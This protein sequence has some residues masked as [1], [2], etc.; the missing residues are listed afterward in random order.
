MKDITISGSRNNGS[1]A[2]AGKST[3]AP[4]AP[5]FT[6]ESETEMTTL[7]TF[8]GQ[9][10]TVTTEFQGTKKFCL[11]QKG[12]PDTQKQFHQYHKSVYTRW[13]KTTCSDALKERAISCHCQ[14]SNQDFLV[15]QQV[16]YSF[17]PLHYPDPVWGTSR[18][19]AKIP[20]RGPAYVWSWTYKTDRTM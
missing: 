10:N 20:L 1:S 17:Y 19:S 4:P 12:G 11:F 14:V 3:G 8:Q 9:L 2:K 16:A 6:V 15:D 13:A 18:Q 5:P 7:L